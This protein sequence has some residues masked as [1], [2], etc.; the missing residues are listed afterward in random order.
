MICKMLTNDYIIG[1]D[2]NDRDKTAYPNASIFS[3]E[4][5]QRYRNVIKADLL[6]AIFFPTTGTDI[7]AWVSID[8]LNKI[9]ITGNRNGVNSAFAKIPGIVTTTGL[10]Y[11]D[12]LVNTFGERPYQTPIA[13][14][15]R[16]NIKVMTRTGRLLDLNG[17][18]WSAQIRIT[19]GALSPQGGG[20]T[21]TQEGRILG[22]TR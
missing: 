11:V 5:P 15:D 19:C 18:N 21:I 4:L 13:T 2:S 14:L 22:G 9:D 16:L 1:F 20:T 12:C 8:Q 17:N 10:M 6:N 7:Y 3:I